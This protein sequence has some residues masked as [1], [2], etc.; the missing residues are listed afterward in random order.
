M[1]RIWPDPAPMIDYDFIKKYVAENEQPASA[2]ASS[3]HNHIFF[4]IF[5]LWPD[6]APMIDYDLLII[7]DVAE[8]EQSEN[9][10][11]ARMTLIS[12]FSDSSSISSR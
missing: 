3:I 9:A 10:N 2:V 6:P 11:A 5:R 7:K 1:F 4:W 8:N 12:L